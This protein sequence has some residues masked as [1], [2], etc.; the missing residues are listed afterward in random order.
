MMQKGRKVEGKK[1][2]CAQIQHKIYSSIRQALKSR[3]DHKG[4]GRVESLF[5]AVHKDLVA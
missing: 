2:R 4:G 3:V 5:Y 1:A